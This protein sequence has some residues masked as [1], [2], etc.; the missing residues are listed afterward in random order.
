MSLTSCH[1]STALHRVDGRALERRKERLVPVKVPS[2]LNGDPRCRRLVFFVSGS[3]CHADRAFCLLTASLRCSDLDTLNG[4]KGGNECA[5][6]LPKHSMSRLK[7]QSKKMFYMADLQ[8]DAT[9]SGDIQRLVLPVIAKV[10]K[11][12]VGLHYRRH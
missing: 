11:Q 8:S 12:V 4:R 3:G 2:T 10:W 6:K 1:C 5:K 7:N 9:P